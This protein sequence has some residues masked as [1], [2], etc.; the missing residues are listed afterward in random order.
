MTETT[1]GRATRQ[2]G[3]RLPEV[4]HPT[5]MHEYF[6][7]EGCH[8]LELL[9]T[10]GDPQVSIA[11]ARVRPGVRTRLHRLVG[12]TERYVILTGTG[13]VEVG[14]LTSQEVRCGDVVIIPP[15]CTQR[16][17]NHGEVDLV[18]LAICTPR[19][20]PAAYEDLESDV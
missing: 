18:F 15:G 12:I 14:E 4:L 9:N 16:I 20:T 6:F 11:R 1:G 3:K 2:H 17:S 5:E 19:F 13:L 10:R 7:H 8:I